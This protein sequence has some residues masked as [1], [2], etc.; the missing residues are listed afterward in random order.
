MSAFSCCNTW[1]D[2]LSIRLCSNAV[3]TAF[4]TCRCSSFHSRIVG[5]TTCTFANHSCSFECAEALCG[6]GLSL[7]EE[8]PCP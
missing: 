4:N 7:S 2:I 3:C 6:K 5:N 1:L 8:D